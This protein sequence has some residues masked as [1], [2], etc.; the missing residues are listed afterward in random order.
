M[1]TAL[2]HKQCGVRVIGLAD[3]NRA[4][5]HPVTGEIHVSSSQEQLSFAGDG[6]AVVTDTGGNEVALRELLRISCQMA[7]DTLETRCRGQLLGS[8]SYCSSTRSSRC[9]RR[10]VPL[11]S[12]WPSMSWPRLMTVLASFGKSCRCRNGYSWTWVTSTHQN[13]R[14]RNGQIGSA[15]HMTSLALSAAW[16]Y[17]LMPKGVMRDRLSCKIGQLLRLVFS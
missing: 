7:A 3:G 8:T 16:R 11:L 4:V 5:L 15:L 10:L 2:T 17:K 1:A 6:W 14:P 9:K 13:G 12:D